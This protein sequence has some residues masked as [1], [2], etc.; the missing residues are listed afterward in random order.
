MLSI[1]ISLDLSITEVHFW[2]LILELLEDV[3]LLLLVGRGQASFLLALVEH[4]LLNHAPRVAV[5]IAQLA[6]LRRDLGD[7]NLWRT[8]DDM[9]P[10]LHLVGLVEVD[11]D[12][13][14]AATGVGRERPRAVL[15]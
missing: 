13:L 3:H 4:H 6:V 2:V 11:L 7:V 14:C 8:G 12:R 9:R 15:G 1:Q 5:E 10:P